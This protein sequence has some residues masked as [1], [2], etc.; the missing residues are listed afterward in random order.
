[1]FIY[2]HTKILMFTFLKFS[3]YECFFMKTD[4][5]SQHHNH[6]LCSARITD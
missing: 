5:Y 6:S 3:Y 1:M 4:S 2:I